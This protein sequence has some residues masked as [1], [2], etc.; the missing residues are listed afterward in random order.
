MSLRDA[1]PGD[2]PDI[3]RLLEQS[4]LPTSD[5]AD[6][7]RIQFW[8][9]E[10]DGSIVGAVGLERHGDAG[11]LRSLVVDPIARGTGLGEAL[12]EMAEAAASKKGITRLALLTETARDFFLRRGYAVIA[13]DRAPEALKA[14]TEFRLLC[15]AS[16]VC[17][18][19]RLARAAE[20][21]FLCTGNSCR[22]ILGE[23]IFNHLAPAGWHASSAGSKPTGH[24]H[25]RSLALLEREGIPTDGCSSKSWDNLPAAPDIVI[26]VCSSAAGEACPAYLGPALRTHWGVDDP[27]HVKGTELEVSA[28]FENAY[29]TLRRRI[30]AFFALPLGELVADRA[31]LKAEIDRIGI[32]A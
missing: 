5:L 16:A 28:A 3:V 10:R 6:P 21:L 4:K 12:V 24:V 8:I 20:V 17:M 18:T 1:T 32:T 11:L 25:P 13:R 29:R 2:L 27:A 14:S 7:S 30:E 23:A 26:T 9:A 31:K 22:S 15:P 19:K